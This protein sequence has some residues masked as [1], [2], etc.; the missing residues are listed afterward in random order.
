MSLKRFRVMVSV[1]AWL[2]L[3]GQ[4]DAYYYHN[5]SRRFVAHWGL[6][7]GGYEWDLETEIP[8]LHV[9]SGGVS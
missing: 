9:L 7:D 6:G 3:G 5:R 8:P 2:P 4:D 1:Q